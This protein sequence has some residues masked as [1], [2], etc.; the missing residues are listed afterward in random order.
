MP[1]KYLER[2]MDKWLL[3]SPGVSEWLIP[4]LAVQYI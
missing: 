3:I 4:I 1:I 2:E